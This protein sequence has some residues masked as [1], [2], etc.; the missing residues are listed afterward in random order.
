MGTRRSSV[1]RSPDR[2]TGPTARLPER[3]GDL[4]SLV[5]ELSETMPQQCDHATA[6]IQARND[7]NRAAD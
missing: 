1:L 6:E 4:R 5:V 7:E 2:N 3:A